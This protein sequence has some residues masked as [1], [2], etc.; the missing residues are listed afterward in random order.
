[1]VSGT[2]GPARLEVG[3]SILYYA[4]SHDPTDGH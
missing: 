4:D 3:G 2:Y 1:M